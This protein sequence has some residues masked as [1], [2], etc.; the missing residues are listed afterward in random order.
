M[1]PLTE[2]VAEQC[3]QCDK[4]FMVLTLA[5]LGPDLESVRIQ[6]FSG[7]II[8]TMEEGV[9]SVSALRLDLHDI[10]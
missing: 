8:L 4:L 5:G 7:P 2:N 1:L 6:L 3:V 10:L 9:V